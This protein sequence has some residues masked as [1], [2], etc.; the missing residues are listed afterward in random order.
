MKG[1]VILYSELVITEDANQ[2]NIII[3]SHTKVCPIH[4][5]MFQLTTYL[6]LC[7]GQGFKSVEFSHLPKR[8]Q[9]K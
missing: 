2:V 1:K 6:H 4:L 5:S 8:T 3:A 9:N 7:V